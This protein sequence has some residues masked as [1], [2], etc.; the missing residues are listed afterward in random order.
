MLFLLIPAGLCAS[1]T[2]FINPG[3]CVSS[4]IGGV[5]ASPKDWANPSNA[6]TQNNTYAT[7][8]QTPVTGYDTRYLYCYSYSANLPAGAVVSGI[9][10]KLYRK[11]TVCTGIDDVL[12]GVVKTVKAGVAVGSTQA[13]SFAWGCA[14]GGAFTFP[15]PDPVIDSLW[16]TT[17]T[18]DEINDT[19]WGFIVSGTGSNSAGIEGWGIDVMQARIFYDIPAPTTVKVTVITE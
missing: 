4:T 18:K 8:T 16:G 9:Q 12:D 6:L 13:T 2:G 1:D 5:S 7:A 10:L 11:N 14:D 19:S 17:F 3:V 15:H